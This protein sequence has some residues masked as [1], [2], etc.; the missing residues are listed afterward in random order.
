MCL[1]GIRDDDDVYDWILAGD[2][3]TAE[4]FDIRVGKVL[5]R[6]HAVEFNS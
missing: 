2:L 3:D 1:A 6:D 5:R 4:Y